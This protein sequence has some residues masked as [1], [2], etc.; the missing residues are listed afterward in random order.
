MARCKNCKE[1][2]EPIRFNQK[3]CLKDE[4]IR[5]FV[6]E[7]K[8]KQWKQTKTRMKENLKTTSDWLKEAQAVFNKYIRERDKGLNCISCNKPPL[9]KNC[10][11]YYSQ[12]GHSNVRFDEDNCHLQCEHCNTYLSGNLLNYQIGIEKRIGAEKLIELQG[13]AHL[14]KKWSVEELKEIIKTYKQK[15]KN[16]IQ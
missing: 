16:E 10:G 7:T 13:R 2:F 15:I 14:E 11:H 9:K 8:E 12:G 1:K 4:C 3:Y 6:A 5:V